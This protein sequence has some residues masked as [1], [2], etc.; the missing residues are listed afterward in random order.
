MSMP[1]P[2]QSLF[3]RKTKVVKSEHDLDRLARNTSL[4]TDLKG[5]EVWAKGVLRA[6][7]LPTDLRTKTVPGRSFIVL[8]D[9][10]RPGSIEERAA[11]S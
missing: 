11:R 3:V 1:N 5:F 10:V 8:F 4:E 7:R 2:K 9:R 6:A